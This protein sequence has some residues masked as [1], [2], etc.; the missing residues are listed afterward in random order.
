MLVINDTVPALY[1]YNKKN[2]L[3]FNPYDLNYF[4]EKWEI[5]KYNRSFY[6]LDLQFF[7]IDY[8]AIEFLKKEPFNIYSKR[9]CKN[10]KTNELIKKY[11]K[12]TDCVIKQINSSAVKNAEKEDIILTIE[13]T[14]RVEYPENV[15]PEKVL[16]E[17]SVNENL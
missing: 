5:N 2:T 4:F 1:F 6:N 9:I 11:F 15:I 8:D 12:Y 14:N 7:A 16:K 17:M 13:A 10:I 3:I